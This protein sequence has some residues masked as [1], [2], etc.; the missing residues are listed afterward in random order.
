MSVW[1]IALYAACGLTAALSVY[2]VAREF[3]ADFVLLGAAALVMLVWGGEALALAMRDLRGG[4]APDRITLYGYL[5]T[6][7]ALPLGAI[8]VGVNERSRWGSV[9][10]L[11]VALTQIVLQM[12]LPQIWPGG[13]A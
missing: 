5:A 3:A 11:A 7:L 9:G 10:I 6:G 4:D 8:W 2:Y 13:F 1:A 12:R